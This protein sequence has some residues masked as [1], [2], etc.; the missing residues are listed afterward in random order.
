M[1]HPNLSKSVELIRRQ[2]ASH[3]DQ[4]YLESNRKESDNENYNQL[5]KRVT[6]QALPKK[7]IP[8][9]KKGPSYI[10]KS[11]SSINSQ[12]G[13]NALSAKLI[14]MRNKF[15]KTLTKNYKPRTPRSRERSP[16][17]YT[18][19]TESDSFLQFNSRGNNKS[20]MQKSFPQEQKRTDHSYNEC[21][22]DIYK[23][24]EIEQNLTTGNFCSINHDK[25]I[26]N[27]NSRYDH[28]QE[29]N[30]LR[31]NEQ[32]N[33]N[34]YENGKRD[35]EPREGNYFFKNSRSL[36]SN[37][38]HKKD[39]D[40]KNN[41]SATP[42]NLRPSASSVS[43]TNLQNTDEY[44]LPTF[45]QNALIEENCNYAYIKNF[46]EEL[47]RTIFAEREGLKPNSQLETS[48]H[49][50]ESL[51]RGKQVIFIYF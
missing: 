7:T 10:D 43:M 14:V 22:E 45:K 1:Y 42:T 50:E 3:P 26:Q 21:S 38:L 33:R 4:D 51:M 25:D 17:S 23:N 49:I 37:N 40:L 32:S 18:I 48:I 46:R 8:Q 39:N 28:R 44:K 11:I 41:R 24:M 27:T 15:F 36:S 29:K 19:T 13:P 9:E 20:P 35:T 12:N 34:L 30:Y 16:N 31:D 5:Y 2:L 47:E 6:K